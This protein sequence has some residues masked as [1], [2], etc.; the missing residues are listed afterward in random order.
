M[1]R[2][3][4]LIVLS[5]LSA[6]Y[7][8]RLIVLLGLS[9]NRE[10]EFFILHEQYYFMEAWKRNWVT[11]IFRPMAGQVR[12]SIYKQHKKVMSLVKCKNIRWAFLWKG[13]L[14]LYLNTNSYNVSPKIVSFS[15]S[16]R[17]FWLP[18]CIS[19]L[20]FFFFSK[21]SKTCLA[22]KVNWLNQI[23][24]KTFYS[25]RVIKNCLN[26][27]MSTQFQNL[28]CER[29]NMHPSQSNIAILSISFNK[30]LQHEVKVCFGQLIFFLFSF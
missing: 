6:L 9:V 21:W 3:L 27:K 20:P 19:N 13:M 22:L 5:V 14:L 2:S 10:N 30:W 7:S 16:C 4:R 28:P 26:E 29:K 12:A 23:L 8:L 24:H 1:L 18:N 11:Q 15:I 17:T 25:I